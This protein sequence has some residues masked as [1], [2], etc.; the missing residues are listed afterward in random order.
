MAGEREQSE[1]KCVKR[2]QMKEEW[3]R[4]AQTGDPNVKRQA[5]KGKRGD[6]NV[7]QI[8]AEVVTEEAAVA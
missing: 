3:W 4:T 6:A 1:E 8:R 5:E 7:V 2:S